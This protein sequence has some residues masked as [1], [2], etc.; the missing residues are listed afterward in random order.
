MYYLPL[1]S[2]IDKYLF[3]GLQAIE[4]DCQMIANSPDQALVSSVNARKKEFMADCV[5]IIR[6]CS[7]KCHDKDI[8]SAICKAPI[9]KLAVEQYDVR[10][11][12]LALMCITVI[13]QMVVLGDPATS[14]RLVDQYGI[15]N[16][17]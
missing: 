2:F 5:A 9:E 13:G 6:Q 4:N 1:L 11:S 7:V 15:L 10:N 17:L 16:K 8:Q 14:Q 12:A 3:T